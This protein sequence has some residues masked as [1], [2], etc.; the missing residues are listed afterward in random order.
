MNVI[1]IH[2]FGED[3]SVWNDFTANIHSYFCP[4]IFEHSHKTGYSL[5]K[6]YAEDLRDFI[7]TNKIENPVLIGHSMGGYIALEYASRYPETFSGLGLFHSSAA[8]DS[9]T[10]KAER[11]KTMQFIAKNGTAVF[12]QNFYPNMFTETFRN[13]NPELIQENIKRFEKL[14][15]E[16]LIAATESMSN[17]NDHLKTLRLL[18]VPVFQILGKDDSLIPFEKGLEQT[19]VIQKPYTLLLNKVAHAGMYESPQI[20]ADFINNFL[21]QV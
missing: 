11:K 6:E 4:H 8:G 3:S 1:W 9:E 13:E 2:G 5:I 14:N 19:L 18:N 20:C 15:P 17:R 10:K 16:A 21:A 12:I 7:V